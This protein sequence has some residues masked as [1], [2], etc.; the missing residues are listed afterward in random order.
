[1]ANDEP[2]YFPQFK[3]SEGKL[4]VKKF[5]YKLKSGLNI[6]EFI[7]VYGTNEHQ[8]DENARPV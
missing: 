4:T 5:E 7:H 1:M 8:K 2:F 6:G 3:F